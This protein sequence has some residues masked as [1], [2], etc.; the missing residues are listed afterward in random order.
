MKNLK[1]YWASDATMKEME[2]LILELTERCN[3]D[4]HK[5]NYKDSDDSGC[6]EHEIR[7]IQ[8]VPDSESITQFLVRVQALTD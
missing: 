2:A 4:D 7:Q 8:K 6:R 1:K 5:S 3:I